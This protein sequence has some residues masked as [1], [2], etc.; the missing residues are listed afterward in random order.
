[1]EFGF[2]GYCN[3]VISECFVSEFWFLDDDIDIV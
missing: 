3:V 2:V 1:M